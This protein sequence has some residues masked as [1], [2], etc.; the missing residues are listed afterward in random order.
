MRITS[1][2]L[3]LALLGLSAVA[4][5]QF[6]RFQF[7]LP[8][9]VQHSLDEYGMYP[10]GLDQII[11]SSK[12]VARV[13]FVS[14][15]PVGVHSPF[16]R[17][18]STHRGYHPAL[19]ITFTAIEYLK[20]TGGPTLKALI[21][22]HNNPLVLNM[23][24][25]EARDEARRL[26]AVRDK[27]WD[28]R[29]ALVFLRYDEPTDQL[30]L[31]RLDPGGPEG[32]YAPRNPGVD[33]TV[34]STEYKAWLPAVATTTA[35]TRSKQAASS[36]DDQLFHLD[37]PAG[38]GGGA[39][40]R[41]AAGSSESTTATTI[42]VG[43]IKS[44]VRE[45]LRWVRESGGTPEA[46]DCVADAYAVI[47]SLDRGEGFYD[48]A[49][50]DRF[51]ALSGQPA[52]SDAFRYLPEYVEVSP[53]SQI[54]EIWYE[55]PHARLFGHR[56]G[57]TTFTRPLPAGE[58][59][60]FHNSSMRDWLPCDFYDERMSNKLEHFVT[61]SAPVGTLAESFFD[62]YASSTAVIGTTTVGTISW[63]SGR[64]T[65]DL[66]I[67]VTGH[68]LDFIGLDGTT[69]LSLIVADATETGGALT[70]SVPT[71]PWSA[72][73]KLMLRIRRHEAP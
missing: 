23:S 15:G 4:L 59:R 35:S 38:T 36:G 60:F 69:T 58:Y 10:A 42:S 63:Q 45:V 50:L 26:L 73:D 66:T 6:H 34:A 7:L 65:A 32:V 30:W 64:V 20:G 3:L 1:T 48:K 56:S 41:E 14:A 5:L 51:S 17:F 55:G 49:I 16:N 21:Y 29:E 12:V 24:R 37:A 33:V 57:Y 39:V 46:E 18:G 44:K 72:G 2:V 40:T 19:E 27:R 28:D 54:G 68:A 70:W 31:G 22:K 13:R 53:E 11:A 61:V 71:Q 67:D 62:P 25:S 43:Q 52:G 47:D 9:E 8:K